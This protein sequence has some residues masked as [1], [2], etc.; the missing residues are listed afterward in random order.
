MNEVQ[1]H[2]IMLNYFNEGTK[3]NTTAVFGA[4]TTDVLGTLFLEI[5]NGNC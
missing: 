3:L 2:N 5:K 1:H 4:M